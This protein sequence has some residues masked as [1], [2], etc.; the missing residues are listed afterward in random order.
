M[1]DR[2]RAVKPGWKSLLELLT[3]EQLAA[4]K[5]YDYP[6]NVREL[7]TLLERAYMT[8]ES[9]YRKIVAEHKEMN[10]G[11]KAK[12]QATIES[13]GDDWPEK[14]KETMRLHVRRV[15]RKYGNNLT[16]AADKLGVS[17]NTVRAYLG[18]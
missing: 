6:G 10:A 12:K 8:D 2:G 18:E 16:L 3:E 14:L 7:L 1:A 11:L 13:D 4:L 5:D 17:R 15:M 9:D